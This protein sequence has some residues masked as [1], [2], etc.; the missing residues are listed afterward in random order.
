MSFTAKTIVFDCANNYGASYLGVRSIEFKLDGTLIEVYP[1]TE[2]SIWVTSQY[3]PSQA[4]INFAFD[5]SKPKTGAWAENCYLSTSY[6]N[7]RITVV[8][9]EPLEFDELIINNWHSVGSSTTYGVRDLKIY[10][11]NDTMSGA[12]YDAEVPNGAMIFDGTLDEHVNS[13]VVDDQ[14]LEIS[15][16]PIAISSPEVIITLEVECS[17]IGDTYV[18]LIPPEVIVTATPSSEIRYIPYYKVEVPE[19]IVT[20][21]VDSGIKYIVVNKVEAPEIFVNTDVYSEIRFKQGITSPEVVVTVGFDCSVT[22][23]SLKDTFQYYYFTVTGAADGLSDIDIPIENFQCRMRQGDPT[24]LSVTVPTYDY[25]EEINAR[26]NGNLRVDVV[27][28]KYGEIVQRRP[29]IT[30]NFTNLYTHQGVK[31]DSVILEGY[32]INTFEKKTVDIKH[33]LYRNVTNGNIRHRLAKPVPSL[34]PGDTVNIGTD[35]FDANIISFY[36]SPINQ[37]MEIAEA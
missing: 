31:S 17:V 16:P 34:N 20:T 29:L 11:T 32:I 15:P 26:S 5:T 3:A 2:C 13:D 35:T 30:T 19:V 23:Y 6:F 9:N 8:W 28:K 22:A 14:N 12:V 27:Y 24:Y 37:T 18:N 10:V 21:E 4:S 36:I 1:Y 7:Q 33:S 25:A